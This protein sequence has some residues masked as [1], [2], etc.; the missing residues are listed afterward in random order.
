MRAPRGEVRELWGSPHGDIKKM[1]G[2]V[3]ESAE[4]DKQPA[5]HAQQP[6]FDAMMDTGSSKDQPSKESKEETHTPQLDHERNGQ[7]HPISVSS[8]ISMD[9]SLPEA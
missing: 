6:A 3:R 5:R 8:D 7:R 4:T 2:K 1:P 9:D